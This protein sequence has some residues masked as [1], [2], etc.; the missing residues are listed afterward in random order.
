MK[1]LKSAFF[2]VSLLVLSSLACNAGG[3][4]VPNPP[5]IT[6]PANV[7]EQAAQLATTAAQAAATAAASVQGVDVAATAQALA[8]TAVSPNTDLAATAQAGITA[9]PS[10]SLQAL[11][12]RFADVQLDANGS[13]SVTVTDAELTQA[14]QAAQAQATQNGQTIALQNLQITFTGG[15]II[16]AGDVTNPV[17]AQLTVTFW[18]YVQNNVLQFEVVSA[19]L[20]QINVPPSLLESSEATLNSTLNQAFNQLP[21][22]IALQNVVMGEG[23]MTITVGQS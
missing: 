22:G 3:G 16:L 20:G 14:V 12:T 21:A 15:N 9:V 7:D 8:E 5:V 17:Q 23:T 1:Q 2:L 18:P 11:Q 6:I 10:D 19:Q 4:S 13:A